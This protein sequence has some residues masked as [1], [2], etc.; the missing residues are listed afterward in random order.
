MTPFTVSNHSPRL[1]PV[2]EVPYEQ[3]K[4]Q[5]QLRHKLLHEMVGWLY[6]SILLAEISELSQ[7]RASKGE[8]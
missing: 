7:R 4:E 8:F 3:I 1:I 2:A 6:P 5:I